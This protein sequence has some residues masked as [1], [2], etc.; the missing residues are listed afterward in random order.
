[1]SSFMIDENKNL[2][3]DKLWEFFATPYNY[4]AP[5]INTIGKPNVGEIV[6]GNGE[7]KNSSGSYVSYVRWYMDSSSSEMYLIRKRGLSGGSGGGYNSVNSSNFSEV[8]IVVGVDGD[9][10]LSIPATIRDLDVS[11][12]SVLF[13]YYYYQSMVIIRLA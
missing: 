9:D 3:S 5:D 4:S 8:V 13:N 6:L 12:S 1:M 11:G 10:Y 2:V 7:R